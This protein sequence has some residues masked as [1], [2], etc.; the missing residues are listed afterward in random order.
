LLFELGADQARQVGDGGGGD[1]RYIDLAAAH[2][3]HAR[4][5]E[6][7]ALGQRDPEP[8]HAGIGDRQAV[9]TFGRK[10]VE[11]RDN[12]AT[13]A[14]H[15]AIAHH[16]ELGTVGAGQIV[17]GDEDLV[18]SKLGGAVEIDRIGGLVGRQR[19]H[20]LNI[21]AQRGVDDVLGPKDIG[22]N[23]LEGVI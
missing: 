3:L 7:Y 1:L 23:A 12:R 20:L 8:R 15:I 11:E 2:H 9:G 22:A 13:A 6:V 18:G 10:L 19:D 21:A 4:Q 14:N 17:G 16:G 5:H